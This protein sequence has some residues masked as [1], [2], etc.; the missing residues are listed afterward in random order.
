MKQVEKESIENEIRNMI[1][2]LLTNDIDLGRYT[3][4]SPPGMSYVEYY[5]LKLDI[6]RKIRFYKVSTYIIYFLHGRHD[7]DKL[8]VYVYNTI[9]KSTDIIYIV[10]RNISFELKFSDQCLVDDYYKEMAS[11]IPYC[12]REV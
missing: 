9:N 6:G 11:C 5:K 1:G 10:L 4:H 3:D 2:N 7:A 8:V 12:N